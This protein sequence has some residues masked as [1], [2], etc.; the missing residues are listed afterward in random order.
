M[1]RAAIG[2]VVLSVCDPYDFGL[3][4]K[5]RHTVFKRSTPFKQYELA[6]EP[7]LIAARIADQAILNAQED[8]KNV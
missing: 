7:V 2:R 8:S 4:H 1:E 5:V 3:Y 6:R